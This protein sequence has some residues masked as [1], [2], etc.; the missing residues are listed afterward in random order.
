MV[1]G[2]KWLKYLNEATTEKDIKK[3]IK[4][5]GYLFMGSACRNVMKCAKTQVFL[6][7]D[8]FRIYSGAKDQQ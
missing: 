5:S 8:E 6:D 2:F 7:E 3:T 1:R 4:Q